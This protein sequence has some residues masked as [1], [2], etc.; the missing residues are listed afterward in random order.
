MV[1]KSKI[2]FLILMALLTF[3]AASC[4]PEPVMP[5]D[6]RVLILDP[7]AGATLSARDVTIRTFVDY[8]KLTDKSGQAIQPGEGHL[9]FYMDVTPPVRKGDSALTAEGTYFVTINTSHTWSA[10]LPGKH[11]F[12]VQLVNNDNTPL[13]PAAAVRVPVTIRTP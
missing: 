10:V 9:I 4:Q 6:A 7:S 2:W 3:L 5:D 1:S 12:W 11:V 13:E 8:F